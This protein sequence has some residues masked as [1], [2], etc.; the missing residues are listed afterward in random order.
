MVEKNYISH[1]LEAR[2]KRYLYQQTLLQQYQKGLLTVNLNIPG[3]N[4]N[5]SLYCIF[6]Q[7][8]M[9]NILSKFLQINKFCLNDDF[10]IV[11][12]DAGL[13]SNIIL[14]T[15]NMLKLI[16][17]KKT[18]IYLEQSNSIF[19]LLDMDVINI[20]HKSIIRTNLNINPRKCFLCNK[21]AKI[22]AIQKNHTLQELLFFI[23]QKI[24]TFVNFYIH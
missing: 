12:D 14:N 3:P 7:V 5:N 24:N 4:K 19:Q 15:K 13:Y 17:I 16:H 22:C 6:F 1:I 8:I 9:V 20:H 10:I 21:Y 2:E 11:S 18:L 23:E